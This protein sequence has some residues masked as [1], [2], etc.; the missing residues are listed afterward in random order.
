MSFSEGVQNGKNGYEV[1]KMTFWSTYK[2]IRFVKI[3]EILSF[4]SH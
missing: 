4:L 3:V 1:K 2:A